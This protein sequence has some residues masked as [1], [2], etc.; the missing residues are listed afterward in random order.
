MKPAARDLLAGLALFAAAVLVLPLWPP[1]LGTADESYYL[2]EAK[3]LLGGEVLYREVFEITM[4]GSLWLMAAVYRVF[5]VD[6][7]VARAAFAV[8]HGLTAV[9]LFTAARQLGVRTGLA[10]LVGAAHL[11]IG[12]PA[13]PFAS[14]HWL[15]SLCSA[16]L[17]C[18]L[19][20]C[21]PRRAPRAWLLPGIVLGLLI[22]I[23][24]QR[25]P[26]YLLG[27]LAVLAFD[28]FGGAGGHW[29]GL[30]ARA[31]ALAGG[32]ALILVPV[33]AYLL[34][35]SGAEPVVRALV[36]Y[37]LLHYRKSVP[38]V[39]WG[40]TTGITRGFADNTF[41][42]LLRWLPPLVFLVVSARLAA[43]LGRRD[44]A[45]TRDAVV[46]LAMGGAAVASIA[47]FPDFIHIA[48]AAGVFL[49]AAADCAERLLR[50]LNAHAG[51]RRPAATAVAA[52]GLLA[53]GWH[54]RATIV[55]NQ[56]LT[57]LRADTAF[58]RVAFANPLEPQLYARVNALLDADPR[59]LLFVYPTYAA[60]YLTTGA[61]NPTPYQVMTKDYGGEE[62]LAEIV[63]ILERERP[64]VV[65][66]VRP[67]VPG[68]TD[69]VTAYV[70]AHY[71]P[72]DGDPKLGQA[73]L[74][75]RDS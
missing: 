15:G 5:G 67:L 9:L 24:H 30:L 34:A 8:V 39:P 50:R 58:G 51:W 61:H 56:A 63:A 72:T 4:P 29:R 41:P 28:A 55:R 59:R 47:Y 22:A 26:A 68:G 13:W 54:W 1:L 37:P 38:R 44:G 42:L 11:V 25:A 23:T 40:L 36:L 57:P 14:P 20:A 12:Q 31:A 74:V 46:L 10:L 73:V 7:A 2:Y 48:F 18:A 6:L 71:A 69:A 35:T 45:A 52:V 60:L 16:A 64:H 75:R 70:D 21:R 19:L 43:A 65:V 32:G 27:T 66:L 62:E 49:V 17:L 53:L 3:R 33:F